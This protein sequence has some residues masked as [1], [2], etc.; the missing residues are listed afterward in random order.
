MRLQKEQPDVGAQAAAAD[1]WTSAAFAL[2][3][4]HAAVLALVQARPGLI[5]VALWYIEPLFMA[6]GAAVVLGFALLVS[7]TRR[8]SPTS[9]HLLGYLTLAA[10]VGSLAAFRTYPSSYD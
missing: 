2:A 7:R 9:R 3:A 6:L 1:S 8:A 5:A 10:L 4:T